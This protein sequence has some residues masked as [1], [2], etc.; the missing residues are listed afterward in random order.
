M[1]VNNYHITPGP[2]NHLSK[3]GAPHF[4][5]HYG[6]E[7]DGTLIQ[8]N[9]LTQVAW[10]TRGQ[11]QVGISCMLVGNF[12]GPGHT[13]E[14]KPTK[15]QLDSLEFLIETLLTTFP[16]LDGNKVFGH[17]D[18]GKPACPGDLVM[19]TVNSYKNT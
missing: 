8:A 15:K 14:N 10:H 18:F 12:T 4:S 1:A 2:Q 19:D 9:E 13:G 16:Q 11:N 6:I 3:R 5:Y 17:C 7:R